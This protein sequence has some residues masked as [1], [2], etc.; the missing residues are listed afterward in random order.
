MMAAQSGIG[1]NASVAEKCSACGFASKHFVETF[2][3]LCNT[4]TDS[5]TS[6]Q[7]DL[8]GNCIVGH[9]VP[10]EV[11]TSWY[12]GEV[13]AY[14]ESQLRPFLVS[15]LHGGECWTGWTAI[16][17]RP[18][19]D[20]LHAYEIEHSHP[21]EQLLSP[22][23]IR[24]SCFNE[25]PSHSGSP[26]LTSPPKVVQL[27]DFLHGNTSFGDADESIFSG[28]DPDDE[29]VNTMRSKRN[30]KMW[31]PEE[32]CTLETIVQSLEKNGTPL[33]WPTVAAYVPGRSGKQCRERYLN[34]LAAV[35]KSERWTAQEDATLFY[36]CSRYGTKWSTIAKMFHG[37]TDHGIKN[38]FHHL[39]R[40]IDKD[41]QKKLQNYSSPEMLNESDSE[42]SS[43]SDDNSMMV[44]IQQKIH[45]IVKILAAE[46]MTRRSSYLRGYVFGPFVPVIKK[47][48]MCNRCHF[49]VP[50]AHCG[51]TMCSNTGWCKACTR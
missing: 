2:E 33:K 18:A 43:S 32:D 19:V 27:F 23:V 34:H 31:T 3:F 14:D 35:L 10:V 24:K 9:D 37:R 47:P 44:P 51:K 7:V 1:P 15:F 28:I 41:V 21:A 26:L 22:P 48:K 38:R 13:K 45:K 17:R 40:R 25:L 12:F 20:Y 49:F 50:S 11:L 46:S 16:A 39:R 30:P 29:T 4:D 42:L 6:T 5:L 36:L 8:C